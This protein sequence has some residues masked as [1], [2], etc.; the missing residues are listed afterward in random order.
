MKF[1][2]LVR[3]SDISESDEKFKKLKEL[4]FDSCQ[5]VYKPKE[6][7]KQDAETIKTAAEKSGIE[8]SAQ[9]CGFYDT[10]TVYD[11]YYGFL[12][13]GLNI[14]AYRSQRLN[15][16][17][18]AAAFASWLG[19]T[20]IIIHGGFIPNNPFS[21]EYA[22]M[23]VS[24]EKLSQQCGNFGLNILFETGAEAP[25][26]LLRLIEDIGRNNLF[27]NFDPANIL[28]YGYGNPVDALHVYGKYVRNIHGKDGMLPT[29]PR[30]LGI[31]KP[32]GEGMVDFPAVFKMLKILGYDRYITIERE[33][34]GEQQIKDII[35]AKKYF[36]I[37]LNTV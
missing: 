13:A 8:I 24:I 21:P 6:Y 2:T 34:T 3:I 12:T 22:S 19:I 35:K 25:I 32:A 31:E 30:K 33:I 36:E 11:L 26:T 7:I 17:R 29:N 23:L 9:F 28:M 15:Y 5:L 10:E 18:E 16:V 37:V 27:I 1:G 4:G 14:E 20:D